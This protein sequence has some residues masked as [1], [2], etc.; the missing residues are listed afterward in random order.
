M[1]EVTTPSQEQLPSR[2]RSPPGSTVGFWA[3]AAVAT[4]ALS[5]LFVWPIADASY[6][7]ARWLAEID[8]GLQ[9]ITPADPVV[10]QIGITST[11]L[12][13][14]N[15]W[16]Q[17][18]PRVALLFVIYSAACT[19]LIVMVVFAAR[20]RSKNRV[21]AV[22][23]I[24][25]CG[26]IVWNTRSKVEHW[27]DQRRASCLLPQAETA[28]AALLEH[29]PTKRSLVRPDLKVIVDPTRHPND[30]V[31]LG[32]KSYPIAE[33]F[34]YLIER[35]PDGAIRFSLSGA[36]DCDLEY[37]PAGSQPGPYVNGFGNPS[38]PPSEVVPLKEH[39]YFVRYGNK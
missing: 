17:L 28:A 2:L 34:G 19:A 12:N 27:S 21:S 36:Y 39:W 4:A 38:G 18:G 9:R 15:Q 32:R 16:D 37:H 23:G 22:I 11:M 5:A 1:A 25:L 10:D 3:A 8:L 26:I 7:Y 24:V 35:S 29:W 6:R 20:G 14:A 31:V 13:V 30:L 33:D